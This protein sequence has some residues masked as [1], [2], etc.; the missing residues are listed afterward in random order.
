MVWLIDGAKTDD[1]DGQLD[2][3]G[4]LFIY[5]N[6]NTARTVKMQSKDPFNNSVVGCLDSVELIST[7]SQPKMDQSDKTSRLPYCPLTTYGFI[8]KLEI[9]GNERETTRMIK[10]IMNARSKEPMTSVCCKNLI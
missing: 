6:D 10:M 4:N 5:V 8:A 7:G 9:D 1:K 3:S 2:S